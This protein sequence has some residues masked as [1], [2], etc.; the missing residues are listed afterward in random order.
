MLKRR[1]IVKVIV[2]KMNVPAIIPTLLC[3]VVYYV[4]LQKLRIYLDFEPSSIRWIITTT[5]TRMDL[6]NTDKT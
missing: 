6:K 1:Y 3:H 2:I 4:H 5:T